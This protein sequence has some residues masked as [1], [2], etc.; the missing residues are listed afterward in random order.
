[1]K[2]VQSKIN[3]ILEE[4]QTKILPGNIKKDINILGV[5]GEYEGIDTSDATAVGADIIN[6]KTA[7]CGALYNL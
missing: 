6:G 7:D 5:V 4:K 1:M 2:E 3:E